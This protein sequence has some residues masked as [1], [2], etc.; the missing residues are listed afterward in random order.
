M[1][2]L[3]RLFILLPFLSFSQIQIGLEIQSENHEQTLSDSVSLSADGSI[4][5]IGSPGNHENGFHAGHVRI[6][7]N[8]E[9]VWT[10]IGHDIDGDEGWDM[11]GSSI[12]LSSDGSIVAIGAHGNDSNGEGSGHVKVYEN[13]ENVWTQV[14]QDIEGVSWYDRL[15]KS[16]SLSSDGTIL[17][18]GAPEYSNFDYGLV[19]IYELI[20]DVWTLVVN[21]IGENQHDNFGKSVSLN[22]DGLVLAI[23]AVGN[24][25]SGNSSSYV[26]VYENIGNVWTQIGTNINSEAINDRFGSSVR[27]SADGSVVAIAGPGNDGNGYNSGHVRVYR[28]IGGN[29]T[30][31]G[32][33][34]DGEAAGDRLGSSISLSS[35]G[36]IVAIGATG[37]IGTY[38]NLGKIKIYK[39]IDD[40]WIQIGTDI[41]G[42]VNHNYVGN[43]VSLS[44]D[45]SILAIN[46]KGYYNGFS[47][48]KVYDISESA[49]STTSN[50]LEFIT[51]YPNPT[52]NQFTIQFG[53]S[54]ELENVN[55]YNNLGQLVLTSKETNIN[56]ST[57][58][59][60]LYVV[61][62]KTSNGIAS[63]KIIIK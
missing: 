61:E 8:I 20:E 23:G 36:S 6:Y 37:D 26:K 27:L 53:D 5:A 38:S 60:G 18:I 24:V 29:W 48:V 52:K 42:D 15:G 50:I 22:S 14:G 47:H 12:S 56:T 58:S 62:I 44:S 54:T 57:L 33:D 4:L 31:I 40:V 2:Q 19:R 30:Q 34:I 51:L 32:T 10:Q 43:A 7:E 55:I 39:N 17:A 13:I 46:I 28:N 25:N 3:L 11:F 35:D 45:G 9:G 1:K 59:S 41:T 63:K 49:L 16:V 21:I